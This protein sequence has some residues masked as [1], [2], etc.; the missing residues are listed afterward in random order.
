MGSSTSTQ[1][2]ASPTPVVA[3]WRGRHMVGEIGRPLDGSFL[4]QI[5]VGAQD[6]IEERDE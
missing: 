5:C 3:A 6:E 1:F 2:P 4:G